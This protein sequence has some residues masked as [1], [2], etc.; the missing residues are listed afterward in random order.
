MEMG[1][2]LEPL[3]VAI[4][5]YRRSLMR[6]GQTALVLGA[7][8]VG[9]LA[10]AVAT[11][12]GAKRVVIADIDAGRVD[13]AVKNGFAHQGYL[14]PMKRGK[15]T[16]ENLAIARETADG[17]AA[18]TD[19]SGTAIGEV[20]VVFEC[21][22]V[23]TCVQAAIYVSPPPSSP[24]T[25][26]TLSQSTKPGGRV[27][28]IGMGIPIQTLAI[29]SAAL[30]EVDLVGVFRYANTYPEGISIASSSSCPDLS[31]LVTH[32][33]KGLESAEQ[34]FGMAGRTKDD[35]GDLVLKVVI[36]N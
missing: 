14:V 28:L 10:A 29:S 11:A 31:K 34:A 1:A 13:F 27:M 2:L 23:P 17:V 8:A 6:E 15:D 33:F 5:A 22:G 9:L 24:F 12:K 26:L 36:A 3:G 7:G 19:D 35:K 16:E 30:R 32:K 25:L 4:H 20:D 21:T 18:V